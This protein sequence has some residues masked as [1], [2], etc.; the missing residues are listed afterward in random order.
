MLLHLF[1][2]IDHTIK[3]FCFLNNTI[4]QNKKNAT[5]ECSRYTNKIDNSVD[6]LICAMD[7]NK[8]HENDR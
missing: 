7:H 6:I 4:C 2:M 1:N 3:I 8:D 5:A